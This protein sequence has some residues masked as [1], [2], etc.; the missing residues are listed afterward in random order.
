[1]LVSKM[2]DSQSRRDLLVVRINDTM[3]FRAKTS[4]GIPIFL[5]EKTRIVTSKVSKQ[6]KQDN[7]SSNVDK[8]TTMMVGGVNTVVIANFT[9]NLILASAL[10]MMLSTF[11]VL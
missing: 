3:L 1:M 2:I 10:S 6:M 5:S 4:K 9:M 8:S 11:N 7:L